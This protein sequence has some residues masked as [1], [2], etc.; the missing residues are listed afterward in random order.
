LELRELIA[1]ALTFDYIGALLGSLAFSLLLLPRLG[2][3]RTSL[4]A[5]LINAAVGL[6]STWAFAGLPELS[7]RHLLRARLRG[8]A[9]LVLLLVGWLLSERTSEL[10]DA[11][12]HSGHVVHAEQSRYQR[13]VLS[14]SA[15]D[16]RLF[17]NGHLQFSSRDEARYHEALVHPALTL[18]AT[19]R[20]VLIGGGGDGLAAREVL[21]WPDVA[22]LSVVDLDARMTELFKSDPRLS[23]LNHGSLRSARVRIE[24]RDAMIHLRD[25]AV[26]FDVA[27]LDFPDP[28]SYAVGKLYSLEFYRELAARLSPDGVV[29]VQATSPLFA[30]S[31]F[32]CIE[33]TL[34]AAGFYTLP[35]HVF[36]PSFG[37]WGFVLARRTPLSAPRQIPLPGLRYLDERVLGSL[38]VFP[39][40]SA[41]VLARVNRIDNQALVG[42]YDADWERWN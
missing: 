33:R 28:T 10:S 40:D 29:A 9:V 41:R 12:V 24:N 14:E 8:F 36:V 20:R 3:V 38:F 34:R 23:A 32:W 4:M 25:P 26:A 6:Y 11:A 21:R 30:R 27:I 7:P 18:S 17:L 5:G 13:I 37:E 16:L 39:P 42:Y 2:L 1:R 19:R 15:G 35:Y 22:E 31:A